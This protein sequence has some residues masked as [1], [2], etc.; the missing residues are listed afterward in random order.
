ML[1]E[2]WEFLTITELSGIMQHMLHCCLHLIF[3]LDHDFAKWSI[4]ELIQHIW[5]SI[6]LNNLIAIQKL[7]EQQQQLFLCP[8]KYGCLRSCFKSL[9]NIYCKQFLRNRLQKIWLSLKI[10]YR[11]FFILAPFKPHVGDFQKLLE[12]QQLFTNKLAIVCKIWGL[13]TWP[14]T[15]ARWYNG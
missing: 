11:P 15:E 14:N 2:S 8:V 4:H 1:T 6:W 13:L 10:F 3:H 12:N 5:L 9:Q 7:N